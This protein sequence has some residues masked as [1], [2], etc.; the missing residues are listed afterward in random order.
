M[1]GWYISL[2]GSALFCR[3]SV[4]AVPRPCLSSSLG[5]PC[6][7]PDVNARYQSNPKVKEAAKHTIWS[8]QGLSSR[9]VCS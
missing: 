9:N 7:Q 4:C 2:G 1:I 6:A 8:S 3:L 5:I